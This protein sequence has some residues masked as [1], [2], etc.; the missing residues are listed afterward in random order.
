M[1]S[2]LPD[3]LIAIMRVQQHILRQYFLGEHFILAHSQGLLRRALDSLSALV[4]VRKH[5]IPMVVFFIVPIVIPLLGNL[6]QSLVSFVIVI[7]RTYSTM[8]K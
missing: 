2:K 4:C 3:R 6:V 1:T 5:G 8:R 7:N